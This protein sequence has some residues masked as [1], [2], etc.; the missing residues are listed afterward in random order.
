MMRRE[1]VEN[2]RAG[3]FFSRFFVSKDEE[4]EDE[5]VGVEARLMCHMRDW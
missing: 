2:E 1:R 4:E 3:L 5:R